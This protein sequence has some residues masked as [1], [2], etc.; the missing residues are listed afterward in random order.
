MTLL[1]TRK[2]AE[3]FLNAQTAMSVLEAAV[4]EEADGTAIHAPP[5]GGASGSSRM[6]R[7]VGGALTQMGRAGIRAGLGGAVALLYDMSTSQLLAIVGYPFGNLRVGATMALAARYLSRPDA[8]RIGLLGSG[9]NAM[10]ILRCLCAV[11]PIERVEVYSPTPEHRAALAQRASSALG[12]PVTAHDGPDPVIQAAEILAVAT[13]S[14]TPVLT[15]DDLRAGVHVT[16]MGLSTELDESVY[17]R[18]DQ[19]VAGSRDQEIVDATPGHDAHQRPTSA[20]VYRLLRDGR[21]QR[22]QI[23]ELGALV[24]GDVAP[25]NGPTDI[26]VFR[27][28]RGGTGDVALANYVYECVREQG[29]GVEFDFR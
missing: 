17:L 13:N 12:V 7:M 18:A 1:V 19:F 3:R 11:R 8:R 15:A 29:V 23:I 2:E 20:P 14:A 5:F 16:S 22:E 10:E 28:S 26:N 21:M 24:K 4:R 6:V 27:E 9:A 25:R